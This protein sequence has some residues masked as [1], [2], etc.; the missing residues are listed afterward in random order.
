[1]LRRIFSKLRTYIH[2]GGSSLEYELLDMLLIMSGFAVFA[3]LVASVVGHAS[4]E[5]IILISM[6]LVVVVVLSWILHCYKKVLLVSVLLVLFVDVALFPAI[7]F[8]GGG[9]YSSMNIWFLLG[10]LFCFLLFSGKWMVCMITLTAVMATACYVYSYRHPESMQLLPDVGSI[11]VDVYVGLIAAALVLGVLT[12]YQKYLFDR[13]RQ[14]SIRQKASLEEANKTKS[15]FLA[16]MS[17]EIRTPINTIIGLNEMNLREPLSEEVQENCVNVQR[18]SRM[19]LSLINDV[20]DL[21]K[22]ESGKMEILPRQYETG[23]MLSDLVN[24]H[25]LRA[26]EKNLEFHVDIDPEIPSMLYGDDTRIR[27]ILTN[28]I[29]N[30][31]KYTRQ[32]SVTLRARCEKLENNRIRLQISVMDTG[33][34]IRKE[35]IPQLF[36]SFQRVDQEKNRAIEGTGLGLAISGQLV[37]LMGGKITVD[38]VYQRGSC[39]MLTLD[40]DI[41]DPSP[42]G[43]ASDMLR[44]GTKGVVEYQ[45]SFEAP[46]AQ[47][48]IVDD[49]E[50]NLLVAKKLLR[51]TKVQVD[52]AKS[53]KECLEKT[54]RRFYHVIFMDHMMP[55]MDGVETLENLRHQDTGLCKDTPVVALTA[56]A[57]S[58]AEQLYN[59]YGFAGYLMKP[60]NADLFEAT[61]MKL[62]PPE[63]VEKQQSYQANENGEMEVDVQRH[64]RKQLCITTDSI[65][66]LPKEFVDHYGI[67]IMDYYV[68]T[69]EGRFCDGREISSENLIEYLKQ[70]DR[71]ARSAPPTVRE[72]ENFFADALKDA[73]QVIHL[74]MGRYAS[75]GYARA[76]QAA[77]SFDNVYVA[78]SGHLSS[79]LG[80]AVMLAA[81]MKEKGKNATQILQRLQE[82]GHQISTSFI[83][84]STDSMYRGGRM[85]T[86]VHF[87]CEML[88][89]HPVLSM[90][91]SKIV[92][93]HICTGNTTKA[94]HSY[95]RRQLKGRKDIDT[96][97]LFLTFTGCSAKLRQE[98]LAEVAKYQ[99]F[100]RIIEQQA[101]AAITSNCG[102][103]SFGLLFMCRQTHTQTDVEDQEQEL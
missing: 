70:P 82:A 27:Q 102:L 83:V 35:D 88:R 38:S 39:F 25:W 54:K 43:S 10:F 71:H 41:V 31:I 97:L 58:G 46:E 30:A 103:G 74:S 95:I 12:K 45:Q 92:C 68:E 42:V 52:L 76:C 64:K 62:L 34:G 21:S 47:I 66:D 2:G 101:S 96:Q 50:M 93:S 48:L 61:L 67:R 36:T 24:I 51:Q 98:I 32:G 85:G 33:I 23:A 100:E 18:A 37:E 75:E 49:N 22:I 16:S 86:G 19:L 78:D 20:L 73:V 91:N 7:Y 13:E 81:R 14:L 6:I 44:G 69:E 63:L 53:G 57:M 79:G 55:D 99:T 60:I 72:Y 29:T 4:G 80:L 9:I 28:L 65:S 8:T 11:Y 1:M 5:S 26:H 15:R 84:A 87:I 40:Q 90:K 77:A 94:Y 89:L 59:D 56:N 3:G 17:H